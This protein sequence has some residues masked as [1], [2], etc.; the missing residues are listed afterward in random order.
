MCVCL[1]FSSL[2]VT[3]E[4]LDIFMDWEDFGWMCDADFSCACVARAVA[5]L[6]DL[7][8]HLWRRHRSKVVFE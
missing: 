5:H 7:P 3:G 1:S 6:V 8:N 4:H 2:V